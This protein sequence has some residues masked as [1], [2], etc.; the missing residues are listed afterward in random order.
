MGKF[1]KQHSI[2]FDGN[3]TEV[4]VRQKT[5]KALRTPFSAIGPLTNIKFRGRNMV[6]DVFDRLERVSKG[7]FSVFREL[8]YNRSL[9]DNVTRCDVSDMTRTQKETHSRKLKELRDVDLVR[10]ISGRL[11]SRDGLRT[12]VYPKGTYVINPEMIRCSDHSEAEWLWA[13]CERT[14]EEIDEHGS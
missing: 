2:T 13:Q 5:S 7:A 9:V 12:I 11:P 1:G 3:T 10:S 4:V 6:E 14:E 8:K